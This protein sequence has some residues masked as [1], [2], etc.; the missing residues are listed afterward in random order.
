MKPEI[1]VHVFDRR[2]GLNLAR[3]SFAVVDKQLQ[4][5]EWIC[6]VAASEDGRR[7]SLQIRASMLEEIEAPRP[8]AEAPASSAPWDAAERIGGRTP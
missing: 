2:S 3:G 7:V 8:A 6:I 4:D 1:R 5:G